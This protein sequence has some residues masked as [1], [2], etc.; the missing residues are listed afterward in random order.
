MSLLPIGKETIVYGTDDAGATIHSK[1]QYLSGL[2]ERAAQKLNLQPHRC[3]D[4]SRRHFEVLHSAADIEGHKGTDGRYYLI[5]FSRT[6]PPENPDKE[7]A[8]RLVLSYFFF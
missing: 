1:D 5:D 6:F 4:L 3:A 2:M 8:L 7:C